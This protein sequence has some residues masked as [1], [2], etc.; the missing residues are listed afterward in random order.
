MKQKNTKTQIGRPSS[1]SGGATPPATFTTKVVHVSRETLI[2]F[3]KQR[4]KK[5]WQENQW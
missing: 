2:K 5:K 1:G 4:R 3:N